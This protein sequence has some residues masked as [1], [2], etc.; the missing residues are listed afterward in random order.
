MGTHLETLE[1]HN[2]DDLPLRVDLRHDPAQEPRGL[3]VVCHGFK[4]FR[5]WGFFPWVGEQLAGAGWTSA[6]MD[7]SCNGIGDDPV[8][9][10]RLDLFERNTY[11]KEM[12]DLDRVIAAVR[13]RSGYEGPLGLLGHSRAAVDVM[14]RAAE[15]PKVGAVVT[16]NGV[17]RPLRFT[18]RQLEEWE[19]RGRLEF[20]NARTGQLMAMDYGFVRDVLENESR[21]DLQ[22]AAQRM[23]AAHLVVH[24]R[25]DMAVPVA[26]SLELAAGRPDSA[27]FR[28]VE[29]DGSTHTFGAV[30]PFEGSTPAL[31]RAMQITL[32]WF[33]E[34]LS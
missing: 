25:A 34:H 22:S 32:D 5:R 6:V 12:A 7:F 31:D 4:G 30:H 28:R 33:G 23:G 18:T 14:V 8:E 29:I 16:W 26:E 21:F 19:S 3:I 2:E 10:G 13:E 15:D 24:A 11:S 27:G 20:T 17:G 1:L 9:F